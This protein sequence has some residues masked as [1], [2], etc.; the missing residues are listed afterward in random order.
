MSVMMR[1]VSVALLTAVMAAGSFTGSVRASPAVQEDFDAFLAAF[2]VEASAAGISRKILDDTLDGIGP[3]PLVLRMNE[4]QPEHGLTVSEY[5]DVVLTER[6]IRTARAKAAELEPLLSRIEKTY[7]VDA[8]TLVAIWGLETS[9]GAVMGDHDVIRALATLAFTGRRT[10]Y[11]RRQLLAALRIIQDGHA[12]PRDLKG[13]WAGAMGHTQFIPATYL[14]YAVDHDGDGRRDVWNHPGDALASAAHYL[15]VSG[16]RHG[17]GWGTEVRLREGFDHAL[18]DGSVYRTLSEWAAAGVLPAGD[19]DPVTRYG[20]D[21]RARLILPAG[22]QGPAFVTFGNFDAFLKYNRSVSYALAVSMLGD[23]IAGIERH[24]VVPWPQNGP[25]LS[26][27]E[28]K[29]LQILLG[30]KGY[31]PGP[32]DGI[33]GDRTA[34]ALRAWQRDHG[35]PADGYPSREVFE[36]LRQQKAGPQ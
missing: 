1:F 19:T 14:A 21:V 12:G 32:A 36:V 20:P 3:D 26:A 4:N 30:S 9:F 33:A 13:S 7:G 23:T 28:R 18:A 8:Q 6:R 5:L 35:F 34:R 15:K 27:D 11:A 16:Y 31:D 24:T 29:T 25:P 10:A 22:A 2:R 17:R